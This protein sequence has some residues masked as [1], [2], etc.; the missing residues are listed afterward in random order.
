M[1][2]TAERFIQWVKEDF[3]PSLG[4]FVRREQNSVVV[5][6][7]ASVHASHF[8]ELIALIRSRGAIVE[9]LSPYSPDLNPIENAFSKFKAGLKRFRLDYLLNPQQTIMRC[10]GY[11]S[12]QDMQGYYRKAGYLTEVDEL[13]VGRKRK[14]LAAVCEAVAVLGTAVVSAVAKRR[15]LA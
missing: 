6:D 11:I 9:F 5:L 15:R 7:N 14:A 12:P 2:V 3:L 1:G 4:S 13:D 8:T 10:L